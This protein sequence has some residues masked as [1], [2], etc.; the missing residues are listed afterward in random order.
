[1]ALWNRI[2]KAWYSWGRV[3]FSWAA[4][5]LGAVLVLLA[6]LA[7]FR[8]DGAQA[9]GEVVA[10]APVISS[11]LTL[12]FLAK[13]RPE[14][15]LCTSPDDINRFMQDFI[16]QGSSAHIASFQL[17]WVRGNQDM[18]DF[19]AGAVQGGKELVVFAKGSD[20]FTDQLG[21]AGIKMIP[22]RSL[23]C[24]VPHFTF[25]NLRRSGSMRLAVVRE[26]LPS[27]CIDIYDDR[28]HPQILALARAYIERLE[29]PS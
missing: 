12:F 2:R 5:I 3:A 28:H 22:Y 21:E 19:L 4:I 13:N 1:M 9:T 18:Q 20:E 11:G 17:S 16:S 29:S 14:M 24:E 8:G 27:H 10:A 6:V 25:L 15:I 26:P 7:G 23:T